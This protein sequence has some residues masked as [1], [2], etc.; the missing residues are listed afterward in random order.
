[1]GDL[2]VGWNWGSFRFEDGD[3]EGRQGKFVIEVGG[4]RFDDSQK[5]I[6]NSRK[7]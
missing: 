3:R 6:E 1:M 7:K 4:T 5:M 2:V